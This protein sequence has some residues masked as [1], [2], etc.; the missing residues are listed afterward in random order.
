[1]QI[2]DQ[3]SLDQYRALLDEEESAFD[4]LEHAF[5]EGDRDSFEKDYNAWKKI[6]EKRVQYLS[7]LGVISSQSAVLDGIS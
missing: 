5:E 6:A 3:H 1:M 2:F 7:R 4:E